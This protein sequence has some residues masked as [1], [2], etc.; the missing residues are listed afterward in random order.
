MILSLIGLS[1]CGK[2]YFAKRLASEKGFRYIGCDDRVEEKLRARLTD[3]EFGQG[4]GAVASWLGQPSTPGYAEREALY[5]ACEAETMNEIIEEFGPDGWGHSEDIVIDTTGSVIYLPE[6]TLRGLKACSRIVYL[7]I[8]KSE[9][10]MMFR[11]YFA[12]PKP[13]LWGEC[14]TPHAGESPE[15][16]LRR[17]YPELINWRA[18]RYQR[19]AE[20]TMI[21]DRANRD[22]LSVTRFLQ[23][24][25][26]R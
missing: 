15:E 4:I 16:T 22:R 10:E 9:F 19:L 21:M 24:A 3:S 20:M 14:F 6:S 2:S 12:D 1:G 18:E 13:V 23:L 17:C 26:A 25:G 7:A 5:L 11:Q 8:P